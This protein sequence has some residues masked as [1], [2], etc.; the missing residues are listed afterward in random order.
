MSCPPFC[1]VGLA[2]ED[3]A[4]SWGYFD[5]LTNSI[6]TRRALLPQSPSTP[7]DGLSW[8]SESQAAVSI[9][10][11]QQRGSEISFDVNHVNEETKS[12]T[13]DSATDEQQRIIALKLENAELQVRRASNGRK[14]VAAVLECDSSV[15]VYSSSL[16]QTRIGILQNELIHEREGSIQLQVK[17][18]A[19]LVDRKDAMK[20]ADKAMKMAQ[21]YKKQLEGSFARH[22]STANVGESPPSRPRG[23]S[24]LRETRQALHSSF[25]VRKVGG[26]TGRLFSGTT[27]E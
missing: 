19:A 5:A 8:I 10:H 12:S 25:L 2:V 1:G 6:H 7:K 24:V 9:D 14:L 4:S 22:A 20:M 21:R 26:K 13:S 16:L 17:L 27:C 3:D 18:D 23:S 11:P 15:Q